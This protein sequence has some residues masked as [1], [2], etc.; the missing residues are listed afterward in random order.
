MLNFFFNCL[1]NGRG[2]FLVN[3]SMGPR[4]VKG[5]F[6]KLHR[7]LCEFPHYSL[8]AYWSGLQLAAAL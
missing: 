2:Y 1:L 4:E 6:L 8:G 3:L 5:E 7:Y